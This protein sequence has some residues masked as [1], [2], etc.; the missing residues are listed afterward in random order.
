MPGDYIERTEQTATTVSLKYNK[1]IYEV[2][3]NMSWLSHEGI[4]L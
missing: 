4:F 1:R 3:E 2:I